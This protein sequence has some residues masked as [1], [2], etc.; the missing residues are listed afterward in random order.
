MELWTEMDRRLG[1]IKRYN[2]FKTI[3]TQTVAEHVFNV[4]R[5]AWRIARCWFDL[6]GE[7]VYK[8]AHHHEDTEALSGDFPA[9][10]KPFFDEAGFEKAN[11]ELLG[12]PVVPTDKVRMIV[13]IADLM[14]CFLFFAMEKALGNSYIENHLLAMERRLTEYVAR[15]CPE[16]SN[17]LRDW[18]YSVDNPRS[19]TNQQKGWSEDKQ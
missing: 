2:L 15:K 4:E 7:H 12:E 11:R 14:D 13:K 8:W 9:M 16:H 17:K 3:Q 18:M 19:D 6:Q 10:A 5:M 1:S